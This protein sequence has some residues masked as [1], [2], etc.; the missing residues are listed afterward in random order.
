MTH[1]L[2]S[3]INA[4]T[5]G[6][7][8]NLTC[9]YSLAQASQEGWADEW[10]EADYHID[11]ADRSERHVPGSDEARGYIDESDVVTEASADLK[12]VVLN[13]SPRK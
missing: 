10:R 11:K 6:Q 12:E 9:L 7:M 4:V 2:N 3:E 5:Y 1:Y 8:W 13:L